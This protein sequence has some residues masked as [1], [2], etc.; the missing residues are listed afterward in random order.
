MP[1]LIPLLDNPS[2]RIVGLQALTNVTHH[3]GAD[4]R[5][6]IATYTPHL[7]RLM[8][9]FPDNVAIN[10]QIIVTLAHAIGSVVHDEDSTPPVKAANIRRLNTPRVLDLIFK[11]IRKPDA[12]YS[13]LGHAVDF[14]CNVVVAC[15]DEIMNN[16][17]VLN[18][19]VALFR[20]NNLSVRVNALN[21]VFLLTIPDSEPD[22]RNL[23]PKAMLDAVQR[24]FPPRLVDV[25]SAYGLSKCETYRYILTAN[26]FQKAMIRCVET[27]D[28][29]ALGLKLADFIQ[30][31]EFSITEGMYQVE[32]ERTGRMEPLDCGL[33]FVMWSD[34]LPHC[35][36]A[37]REKG[38]PNDLDAADIV[39]CKYF[40]N[41]SRVADA[42]RLAQQAME[43]S[44]QVAYYHYIVSL[45]A[46]QPVGLRVAKK[47]LKCR[48]TT[49]F[50]KS[51]LL[52]RA[53]D[54]ASRLGMLKL[55]S[56]RPGDLTWSEG[57]AFFTSALE[58][59]KTFIAEA[60][61]D[62]HHMRTILNWFILLTLVMRGPDISPNIRELSVS[63]I[64]YTY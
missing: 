51:Y 50:V 24:Q 6:D 48:K 54:H 59:A 63:T 21:G 20:S 25:V 47:G 43:R 49:P 16:S 29:Y 8:E 2:T 30:R 22:L 1:K 64:C 45:G 37:L 40:V 4:I 9:E 35:A 26:E 19:L 18:L 5:R 41:K 7:L 28:L 56:S 33:P 34:S 36:K 58:D 46:D 61:P 62:N 23:D 11:N 32:N 10:E 13:M 27:H 60:P 15:H 52:W 31:T 39:E 42:V 12:S 14:L 53:V 17:S 57:V 55:N 3:G 38:S 44:P